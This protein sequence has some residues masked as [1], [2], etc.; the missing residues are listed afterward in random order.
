MD[1]VCH[2]HAARPA[3]ARCMACGVAVCQ[4]CA[5]PFDGVMHCPDCLAALAGRRH[6]R[7]WLAPLLWL[8]AGAGALWLCSHLAVWSLGVVTGWF[9]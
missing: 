9:R 1:A 6:R 3:F 5:T 2:R 4:E 8:A 7:P